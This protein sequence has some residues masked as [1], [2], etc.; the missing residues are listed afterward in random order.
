MATLGQHFE[1]L[2]ECLEVAEELTHSEATEYLGI[3]L[4][5]IRKSERNRQLRIWFMQ[6]MLE[7]LERKQ[8]AEKAPVS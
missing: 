5:T 7:L 3:V 4:A 1:R 2:C 6:Q 8:V